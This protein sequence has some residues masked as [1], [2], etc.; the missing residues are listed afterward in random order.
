MLSQRAAANLLAQAREQLVVVANK[1]V[2]RGKQGQ[3]ASGRAREQKQ[4][5]AGRGARNLD[6]MPREGGRK[7]GSAEPPSSPPRLVLA[8]P[9]S[10]TLM[11][12][13]LP[14]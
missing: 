12:P 3:P 8:S 5:L 6:A 10:P 13:A 2:A 14:Y 4:K 7:R 1:Q 11:L 9:K